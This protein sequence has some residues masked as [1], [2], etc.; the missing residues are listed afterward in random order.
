MDLTHYEIIQEMYDDLKKEQTRYLAELSEKKIEIETI[1]AY[2]N[3]LLN[4]EESDLKVFLPRK[5]EQV[6]ADVIEQ[7]RQKREKLVAE[8]DGIEAKMHLEDNQ[9]ERLEKVLAEKPFMI[10]VKQLSILD[11]QEKERQRIAS[12][13]HDT[14]LQNLTHLIHKVELS[15]IYIDEDPVKAK[16]ELATVVKGIK[17][18]IEEIRNSIFDLRPMSIDDLG[19]KETIEKMLLLLNQEKKF[20]I[21]QD[22]DDIKMEQSCSGSQILFLSMY[23]IIQECVQNSV[24]HS[25]GNEITVRLK[26]T[27]QSYQIDVQ[28]NGIGFDINEVA[29]KERHFGLSVIRERVY[30]LGGKINIETQNGTAI[31]IEI[32]KSKDLTK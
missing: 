17:E 26:D 31:A 14:S 32:P 27:G 11:A 12:D 5:V 18:V 24:K 7:N 9:I 23:R 21:V 10:H 30:F 29:K 22:I 25:K 28:D 6:Y 1:D 8:C 16:L 15:A 20:H 13:L 2:L 4:K 3:G 19:M